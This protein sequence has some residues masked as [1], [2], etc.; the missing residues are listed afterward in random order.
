M[1]SFLLNQFILQFSLNLLLT[2]A[3]TFIDLSW[4]LY[5]YHHD[6]EFRI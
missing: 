6:A 2:A 4:T 1:L 3:I 5:F